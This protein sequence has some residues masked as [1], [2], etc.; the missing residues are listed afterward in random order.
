MEWV[1]YLEEDL[2]LQHAQCAADVAKKPR[3]NTTG[4]SNNGGTSS[5]AQMSNTVSAATTTAQL[6]RLTD[7]EKMLLTV[8]RGCYKC[9]VFYAGHMP[10]DFPV[11]RAT[12]EAC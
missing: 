8:H 7:K 11:Y 3:A 2:N 1:R 5:T 4:A 6:P 9:W 10:R 12:L